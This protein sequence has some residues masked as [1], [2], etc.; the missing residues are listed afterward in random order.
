MRI[1]Y[2]VSLFPKLSETFILREI[3]E[4][5]RR[6][7]EVVIVSLRGQL[8]P[9][10]HKEA[11]E[12]AGLTLYPDLGLHPALA[13]VRCALT[14]PLALAAIT[15][16][17]VRS[18]LAHPVI[19]AKTLALLPWSVGFAAKLR[20]KG[21][22]HVHAH[23]A[24]YPATAAWIISKLNRVPYSVTGHAHDIYLPNPMLPLKLS[25]ASFFATISEF[26]RAL[27]IQM[28]GP[29]ALEK[30]RVIHC[31]LPLASFPYAESRPGPSGPPAVVSVGRLVDYK[32]FD[33]LVRACARLR[34][35]GL[36]IRCV[37]VGEGPERGAL[38]ALVREL[39]LE[40]AVTLVGE[41]P[42]DQVRE[43]ISGADAFALASTKGRDGQ[44]D[45]I[46]IVLMEAM[47][48]GVPVISTKISGIPEL[49]ADNVTGLLAAPGDDAHLAAALERILAD[50]ELRERLRASARAMIDKEFNLSRSV[51]M[52]CE[53]F[54]KAS[55]ARPPHARA[56]GGGAAG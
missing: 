41:K 35:K 8:E 55:R 28:C 2:V 44:Q 11:A 34:Q 48:L 45:G 47:A 56:G 14:R 53:E 13:T 12:L 46:P 3:I 36:P 5:R 1:A 15:A 42:Q 25:D 9:V 24:T 50:R 21:V 54:A 16:R 38:E 4:L 18:H 20:A 31:G 32:G 23:W 26:N 17:L 27:L 49:V 40:G 6:G 43:R 29:E 39:G 22:D 52:L 37:V 30:V 10:A 19:L 51:S 33:V 7:H